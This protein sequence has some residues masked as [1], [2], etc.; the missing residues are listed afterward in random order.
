[1]FHNT[2][3]KKIKFKIIEI[4]VNKYFEKY[5]DE[6]NNIDS[7]QKKIIKNYKKNI[8]NILDIS[9]EAQT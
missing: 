8:N 9:N 4:D 5:I 2:I 6:M 1:M 3:L 7:E